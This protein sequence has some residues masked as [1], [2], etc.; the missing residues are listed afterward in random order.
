MKILVQKSG[1]D[2]SLVASKLPEKLRHWLYN[3][4]GGFA[5]WKMNVLAPYKTGNLRRQIKK[6]SSGLE[7][8]ISSTAPYSIFVEEGTRP[9]EIL[10]VNAKA[11]RFTVGNYGE[12]IFAKRVSHPGTAPQPFVRKTAEATRAKIPQFW[13]EFWNSV[14]SW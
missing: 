4:V 8:V 9:H 7:V 13:A 3:T 2:I 12:F 11:L 1:I 5:F 10:P 6:R 14:E